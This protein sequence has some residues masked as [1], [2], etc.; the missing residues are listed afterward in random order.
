MQRFA[1][2]R[3]T[4]G[5]L[6][7]I[8]LSLMSKHAAGLHPATYA[9]WYEYAAGTHPKLKEA[10]DARIAAGKPV[11]DDAI[12]M[13][14][15][16]FIAGPAEAEAGKLRTEFARV[17][18]ELSG[19][20]AAAGEHADAYGTSLNRF[21]ESLRPNAD[22]KSLKAALDAISR[23]TGD[24]R[25]KTGE[26]QAQLQES[27][28]EIQTLR[29]ELTRARGEALTDPLTGITNRRGFEK[30]M[31]DAR[32]ANGDRLTGFSLIMLDI[33][34][35]KKCNDTYGHLFGDKVI[36]SVAQVVAKN[37]KGQDT[38]ARVGGEEFAVLLPD[39]PLEGAR[40][41]AERIRA[42]VG[43]GRI[44]RGNSAELVGNITVSLG[45]AQYAD[46][47]TTEAF[48]GRADEALYASKSGGRNR[49]TVA[50][51]PDAGAGNGIAAVRPLRAANG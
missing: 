50:R 13:L 18:G 19:H 23:S 10:I 41:L 36:C 37:V 5:E 42:S 47:E 32:A 4:S 43:A 14:H 21:G 39:T 22:P 35:F 24:M 11:D 3:E 46:D 17:L 30:A 44:K 51:V 29:A 8:A 9:V 6:L 26:L 33:D 34:H 28:Q 31:Q 27:A 38:P 7:R 45:V 20:A 49:V 12:Y 16:A 48:M 25:Q 1:Q 2:T 40:V 15:E